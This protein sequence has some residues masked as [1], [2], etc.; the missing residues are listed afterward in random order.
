M[1]NP[2]KRGIDLTYPEP[3]R[4]NQIWKVDLEIREMKRQWHE[5]MKTRRVPERLWDFGL[6]YSAKITLLLPRNNLQ[7]RTGYEEVIGKTPD[8]SEYCYFDFY[9]LV[10]YYARVHPSIS[11]ENR[12]LGRWLGV[13][14]RVGSN[15]CY[16]V[17]TRNGS[18]DS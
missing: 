3:E 17:I 15:M 13:S 14:H 16:S 18:G 5:I 7:G 2:R 12:E 1:E 4:K 6:K 9:D 11:D 10:W 8:I